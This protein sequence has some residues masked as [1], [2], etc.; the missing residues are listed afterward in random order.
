M[1]QVKVNG[2]II[3]ENNMGDFDKM[4]TILTPNLG[5]IGC[6]ARG[7]R[8][9]K[10][11]LLSGTQFLC[12]GEYMLF[13][14]SET[15]TMNSCET[16]EMF[17]NIRTDLDKL[18]YASYITKII[19][20]VTTE[21]QNSYQTLKL[22]LNTLYTISETDKNLDFVTSV[23]KLR[24]LKILGFTPNIK[25]CVSCKEKENLRYFSIKDNGF[26]CSNCGKLDTGAIGISE[27]TEN[28]IKYSI[29]ADSKKIFSFSLSEASQNE[30]K[31]IADLYLNDKLEKEY[32]LE[33]LF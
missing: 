26:K 23:F 7:A 30:L 10:S 20:D 4:L 19:N 33:K 13:K 2:I 21:N 8:R 29:L 1:K 22:F 12:F 9:P 31:I 25:E 3:S 11:L 27:A 32:K 18:M 5:K 6:S 17:Y 14:G 24:L 28:A 15:Y 16:I